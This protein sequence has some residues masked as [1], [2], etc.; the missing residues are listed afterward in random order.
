MVYAVPLQLS[1]R[2]INR[3]WLTHDLRT[4]VS[5]RSCATCLSVPTTNGDILLQGVRVG[6]LLFREYSLGQN[7]RF[8][9]REVTASVDKATRQVGV[10]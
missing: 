6:G 4:T 3:L 1:L 9:V 5:V 8:T 2:S 7:D 10:Y